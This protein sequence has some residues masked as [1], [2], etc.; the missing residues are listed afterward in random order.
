MISDE[1]YAASDNELIVVCLFFVPFFN[2]RIFSF[3]KCIFFTCFK[4]WDEIIVF[5][6]LEVSFEPDKSQT[7][8]PFVLTLG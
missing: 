3:L 6:S 7:V 8:P 5:G 1:S 2:Y 4:H